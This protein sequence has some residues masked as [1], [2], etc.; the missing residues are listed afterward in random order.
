[1]MTSFNSEGQLWYESRVSWRL[2]RCL[3]HQPCG[4][5]CAVDVEAQVRRLE[6]AQTLA[7]NPAHHV[8]LAALFGRLA[9]EQH[10]TL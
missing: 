2:K 4:V 5:H 6:W 9:A 10:S 3:L 7:Q 1:M 8:Q